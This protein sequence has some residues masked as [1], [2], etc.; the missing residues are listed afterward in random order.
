MTA[1]TKL[2]RRGFIAGTAALATPLVTGTKAQASRAI[3]LR[4]GS[5]HTTAALAYSGVA[6][7]FFVPEVV[8]R[9]AE[10]GIEVNFTTA[11]GGTVAR[12][13]ETVDAVQDGILD[14]GVYLA[15]FEAAKLFA[16]NWHPWVP[17]GP[18]NNVMAMR[19]TL[20]VHD[21]IPWLRDV[22]SK[23]WNQTILGISGAPSVDLATRNA[24]TTLDELSGRRIAG[25]G[26]LLNFLRPAGIVGVQ[27]SFADFFTS[28]QSGVVD[29]VITVV[30]GMIAI[31]LYEVNPHLMVTRF[32]SSHSGH[33][34]INNDRDRQL[35]PALR[36]ILR[37]VGEAYQLRT[38]ETNDRLYEAAW[39]KWKTFPSSTV[40]Y[41]DDA[42]RVEWAGKLASLPVE[43][44]KEADRRGQPGTQILRTYLEVLEE[45]G[46]KLPV[47]ISI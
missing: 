25:A 21:R 15:T 9:A 14:I 8:R 2:S 19:A 34:T 23:T 36:D 28:A 47:S 41:M 13:N 35:P 16:H 10:K 7:S 37:E 5:G 22:V 24:W 29:G 27:G 18:D 45:M 12:V 30:D 1:F 31:R 46:F 26:A 3:N 6:D 11:W 44:A 20:A 17:F 4:I 39:E 32:G 42:T 33:L 43:Q 40:R 38:A